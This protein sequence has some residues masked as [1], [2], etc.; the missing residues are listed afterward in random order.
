MQ[1]ELRSAASPEGMIVVGIIYF[2]VWVIS[3]VGK[4]PQPPVARPD[5]STGGGDATQQEGLSLEKI[6]RQ[7]EQVKT[8]AEERQ[9]SQPVPR[10]QP[11]AR[12]V[13]AERPQRQRPSQ[14]SEGGPLGRSSRSRLP[15]AEEVEERDSYE[16]RSL[17]IEERVENLDNRT[18][19]LVDQDE[20]AESIIQRRLDQAAARNRAHRS[21]D[22]KAFDKRIREPA[23]A[24]ETERR[25]SAA[26]MRNAVIWR[27]ILGPPKAFEE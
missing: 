13:P 10:P 9:A 5:L 20:E 16:G 7:I 21:T 17:E 12:R 18:R 8:Q 1:E 23:P 3:K 2:I 26:A 19:K 24:E 11:P 25:F 22:H 6:L 14:V 4:K 15:A 27:E